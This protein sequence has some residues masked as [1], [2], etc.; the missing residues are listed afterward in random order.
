MQGRAITQ[1]QLDHLFTAAL[2]AAVGRIEKDGHFHPLVFELRGNGAIHNVAVLDTDTIDGRR[3]VI[4]RLFAILR[5]R[6]AEGRVK[7]CAIALDRHDDA[8]VAVLLRA[9]N[10][11]ANIAVP[12]TEEGK[13][14]LKLKRRLSLGEF[15][16]R[17]VPNELF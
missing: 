2:E 4:D 6:V 11:S 9:P 14:F 3:T 12:Y 8:E 13:G 16:A 17:E 7:A 5:P 15:A 1:D 10:F